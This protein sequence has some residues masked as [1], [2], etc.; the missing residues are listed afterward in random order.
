MDRFLQQMVLSLQLVILSLL[1]LYLLIAN[2][3]SCKSLLDDVTDSNDLPQMWGSVMVW[4]SPSC[5][6][7][8]ESELPG[9]HLISTQVR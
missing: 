9:R 6:K 2:Y 1:A 7:D 3:S 4:N 5:S 8:S